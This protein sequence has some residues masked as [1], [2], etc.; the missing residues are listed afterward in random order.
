MTDQNIKEKTKAE[1]LAELHELQRR[2]GVPENHQDQR[3][4]QVQS[5]LYRIAEAASAVQDMQQF[6]VTIH[7]I[8]G[9]LMH[10]N[11]FFIALYDAANQ[12]INFPYYVDEVDMDLPD[13]EKWDRM[14]EGEGKG[15]TAYVIRAG[16]PQRIDY[17]GLI[18]LQEQGEIELL[19][20]T[21][22][23]WLGVPLKV[24]GQTIGVLV[25]QS[26]TPG[27][28]YHNDDLDLLNFVGQHIAAALERARAIEETRQKNAELAIINSV[29][30]AMAKNLDVHTI[31]RIVGDKLRD[32]FGADM[33]DIQLFDPQT[34][35]IQAKYIYCGGYYEAEKEPPLPLGEGLTSQVILSRKPLLLRTGEEGTAHGALSY[36]TAPE[37]AKDCESYMAVPIIVADK[38][39]GVVDVQSYKPHDFDENNLRLLSTLSS[40]MGV[41]IENARLFEETQ[42]LLK[43]TEQRAAELAIINSV[44]EGLASKL[45][46]Q[47]IYDLV[48]D[49]IRAIFDSQAVTIVILDRET[50]IC[51]APYYLHRGQRIEV[52]A[53]V[54]GEG[55]VSHVIKTRQPLLI[56]ENAEHRYKEF[57]AIFVTSDDNAKSWVGVPIIVG[58]EARGAVYLQNYE[59]ER[60]YTESDVNLLSTLASSMGVALENAHLFD[61]TQRLLKESEQRAAELAIINSVQ[62][63]LASQLD[64]QAIYELVGEKL[65]SIFNAQILDIVTYNRVTG[66]LH[67]RYCYENGDRATFSP[68]PAFGF[69]KH[70]I[71]TRQ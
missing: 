12:A 62:Q 65:R 37:G 50:K 66:L 26:Y 44:Q 18:S 3:A 59:R 57:G 42:R 15:V 64:M 61:E 23:D 29:G 52:P 67:D 33:V 5:A 27:I 6:Y 39:V 20:S 30:E 31:T 46:L 71:Q 56:N 45:D 68:R 14:G 40:N 35:L 32:I 36:T 8:V 51:H 4:V 7:G 9:E 21:A 10:A 2:V 53:W 16:V 11:N 41:A 28:T 34:E 54:Y 47:A 43:E 63:G 48:G 24:E 1:L 13:P 19:G 22:V 17:H 58:D 55:L 70:I 60:A 38:V 69:R 49:K 25:V